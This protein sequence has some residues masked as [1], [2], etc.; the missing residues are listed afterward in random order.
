MVSFM[1]HMNADYKH[2]SRGKIIQ[3]LP[4]IEVKKKHVIETLEGK[5]TAHFKRNSLDRKKRM[6]KSKAGRMGKKLL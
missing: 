1:W 4:D 2:N 6:G 3:R 5:L